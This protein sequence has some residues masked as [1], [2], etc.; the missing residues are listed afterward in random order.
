[1]AEEVKPIKTERIDNP[2]GTYTVKEV[3]KEPNFANGLSNIK[4]FDALDNELHCEWYK[5]KNFTQL[6]YQHDCKNYVGKICD[7]YALYTELQENCWYSAIANWDCLLDKPIH[8]DYYKNKD[9]TDLYC[10]M[11]YGYNNDNS[12]KTKCSFTIPYKGWFSRIEYYN[13]ENQYLKG[14][15][16]SDSNFQKLGLTEIAEYN[17]DGTRLNRGRFEYENEFGFLSYIEYFDDKNRCLG[18]KYY[19]NSDYNNLISTTNYKYKSNGSY[20]KVFIHEIPNKND[21]LS[22]IDTYN[23]N[24][25]MLSMKTF[26]DK[27]F[28][29]IRIYSTTK[30]NSD[31]SYTDKI[32]LNFDKLGKEYSETESYYDVY[33]KKFKEYSKLYKKHKLQGIYE[34]FLNKDE[35]YTCKIISNIPNMPSCVNIYDSNENIIFSKAYKDNNFQILV[36]NKKIEYLDDGGYKEYSNYAKPNS[37]G[38]LSEIEVYSSEKVF[39]S[40]QYFYDDKFKDLGLEEF[41]ESANGNSV[42]K[43]KH[44]SPQK[45]GHISCISIYD[46]NDKPISTIHYKDNNFQDVLS[47]KEITYVYPN[48][49]I[50][51]QAFSE[52]QS[53]GYLSYIS[54]YENGKL[55]STEYFENKDF[56]KLRETEI[57]EYLKHGK[58]ISKTSTEIPLSQIDCYSFI[59]FYSNN[60]NIKTFSYKNKNFTE[61]YRIAYIKYLKNGSRILLRKYNKLQGRIFSEIEKFDKENKSVYK[62]QYKFKGILAHILFWFAR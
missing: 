19:G 15:F 24:N 45:D 8:I 22:Q 52:K 12:Y 10:K 43:C 26:Y 36:G 7:I 40:G 11:D 56:T 9:F 34:R 42:H 41:R 6:L 27:N 25:Q 35:T 60:K 23:R 57:I 38:W 21:E 28:K 44:S 2:D 61:L 14:Q 18:G 48:T 39:Q 37:N 5:N 31:G 55:V 58:Y 51:K 17:Q 62:K 49:K 59:R 20:E 3:Y 29:Q 30:H 47:K 46:E 16:Y 1:M 32:K 33:R 54:K 4:I 53:G 50:S 13:S